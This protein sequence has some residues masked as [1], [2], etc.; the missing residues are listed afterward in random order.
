MWP[1]V[2]FEEA[3]SRDD[4]FYGIFKISTNRGKEIVLYIENR[5]FI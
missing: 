3:C 2:S 4:M 1:Q 5:G